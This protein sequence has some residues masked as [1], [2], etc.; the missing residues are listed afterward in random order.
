M[1]E[2]IKGECKKKINKRLIYI[3]LHVLFAYSILLLIRIP[4]MEILGFV[5]MH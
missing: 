3:I 5:V 4:S 2:A 1:T